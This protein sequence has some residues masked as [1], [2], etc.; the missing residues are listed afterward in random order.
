[1]KKLTLLLILFSIGFISFAQQEN[2][3][4]RTVVITDY[5]VTDVNGN[6]YNF[7]ELL[8]EGKYVYMWFGY[9]GDPYCVDAILPQNTLYEE[10]GCNNH[11]LI[12]LCIYLNTQS[13]CQTYVNDHSPLIYPLCYDEGGVYNTYTT[14]MLNVPNGILVKPDRTYEEIDPRDNII[15][16]KLLQYGANLYDCTS[17][18]L[19]ANFT[20]SAT[21]IQTNE[22]VTFTDETEL[23]ASPITSWIWTFEGGNPSTFNGHNPPAITYA[24]EGVYDVKLIVNDGSDTNEELK[25]DF[26]DV[27]RYCLAGVASTEEG[28]IS[29]VELNNLSKI[30][31]GATGY[32]NFT[33]DTATIGH[34]I[35]I[36]TITMT[37]PFVS[38][39]LY[40]WVD[41]NKDGDFDDDNEQVCNEDASSSP[42]T[43]ELI[44]PP[45]LTVANNGPTRMRIRLNYFNTSD[46]NNSNETPCGYSTYGEVE[47]YTINI[48]ID[49][50]MYLSAG[51]TNTDT[52]YEYITNLSL[53][54]INN[55]SDLS[56]YGNYIEE[57]ATI[58]AT[59]TSTATI[60]IA[61][62]N[63]SDKLYVWVDWNND[64]DFDDT[65]EQVC[66]IDANTPTV[67]FSII[68]PSFLTPNNNGYTR[69]RIRLNNTDESK[70][71]SNVSNE[72]PYGES[73]YGEVED[74]TVRIDVV[75]NINNISNNTFTIYP[76]P[77]NGVFNIVT[78]NNAS[79]RIT[80]TDVSGKLVY[81]NN[82]NSNNIL[83][84]LNNVNK[85]IYFVKVFNETGVE[86]EKIIIK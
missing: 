46:I 3:Q 22:T 4:T 65:D 86:I 33:T 19:N 14:Q 74:Y 50:I 27:S 31:D 61:N 16:N 79:N 11:D 78:T 81:E 2:E 45:S 66:N 77:N 73:T 70:E 10:F 52:T 32:S 7:F 62:P 59:E 67:S 25:A 51:A 44:A 26:I 15:K 69:M 47:D 82:T 41:W 57:V 68:A 34:N 13:E 21:N 36:A 5:T 85:G 84:D 63:L 28:Y 72:T 8:D 20:V 12:V 60:T 18:E 75:N 1:M 35:E 80:I 30:S 83:V 24:N 58:T 71:I 38:D 17:P 42:V 55:S 9:I 23:G 49:G 56:G 40:A 64:G 37:N 43:F 48:N 29:K 6:T 39:S 54:E 53:G 76:N